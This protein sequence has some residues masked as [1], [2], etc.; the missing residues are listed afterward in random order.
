MKNYDASKSDPT[1]V[2]WGGEIQTDEKQEVTKEPLKDTNGR[3]IS[4][5]EEYFI[6]LV[7]KGY[8]I[9]ILRTDEVEESTHRYIVHAEDIADFCFDEKDHE[10]IWACVPVSGKALLKQ[11]GY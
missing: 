2:L 6:V 7:K 9:V 11:E 3:P 5:N 8:S 1:S 4:K 10:L